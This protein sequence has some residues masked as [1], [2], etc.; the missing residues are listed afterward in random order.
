MATEESQVAAA[1]EA[2]YR[3]FE[4]LDL[5]KMEKVWVQEN[6]IQCIH[7]G[8]RVVRGWEAVM[9]SWQRIFQNTQ[10]IR[11][12]L[13]EARIQVRD[14]LAWV[15]VYENLSSRV[16]EGSASAIVLA[17]N[18]YEKRPAGWLMIHHHGSTVLQLPA[19][20]EPSTIH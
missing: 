8:W 10:E 3:A 20:P 1:N 13:T 15:T 12:V 2:F 14:S 16:D 4:S 19:V 17:T 18:I 11:F 6:Y 7:P 9:A 5:G